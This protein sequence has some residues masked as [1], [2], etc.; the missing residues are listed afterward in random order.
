MKIV[1]AL[2]ITNQESEQILLNNLAHL[3]KMNLNYFLL[4]N[5]T[6]EDLINKFKTNKNTL[7]INK[8][9]D[10]RNSRVTLHQEAFK[11]DADMYW[12]LD[13]D[14]DFT[15]LNVEDF[16]KIKKYSK[17]Y[18][19]ISLYY[20]KD[21][22]IPAFYTLA[23]S[24]TDFYFHKQNLIGF[25]KNWFDDSDFNSSDYQKYTFIENYNNLKEILS[26]KSYARDIW[27]FTDKENSNDT[28]TGGASIY[29]NKNILLEE[30]EWKKYKGKSLIW[31]DSYRTF[32]LSKKYR[33]SKVPI[34]VNHLRHFGSIQ[35]SW[36]SVQRYIIGFNEYMSFKDKQWNKE[37]L[38]IHTLELYFYIKGM[39]K[40]ITKLNLNIDEIVKTEINNFMNCN[41]Y[42]II[43]EV[44]K[45]KYQ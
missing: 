2:T 27:E 11:L 40:K 1:Y 20:K 45:W 3:K 7:I 43:E 19:F 9:S 36:E 35:L 15:N 21:S 30:F 22:P 34:F 24:L 13:S 29:F 6:K 17:I 12:I 10:M 14:I 32:N 18:D 28:T 41:I 42:E 44:R 4:I 39:W 33:F 38:I 26:G 23:S 16:L 5:T 25:E 31:Y 37:S 8:V